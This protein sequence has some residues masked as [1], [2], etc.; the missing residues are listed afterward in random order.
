MKFITNKGA[1]DIPLE[2]LE[3]QENGRLVFF[4]GAGISYPAGL[5]VFSQLVNDVFD[6]LNEEPNGLEAQ[7]IK[8]KAFDR[9]LGLLEARLQGDR[10]DPHNF[11]RREI[12]KKLTL[13]EGAN[14]KTHKAL[15]NLSISSSNTH[16]IVT[17]NVDLGFQQADKSV[18]ACT[19]NAPK[20]PVPKEHKW[21][22][23]VHL[24]GIIDQTLD[25]DGEHL[26]FTSGDFGSAYLTERWASKFVTELFL[27]F[28]VVFVGYSID[29]PVMRYIT[30][31]IAA[32][33]RRG[34]QL[35]KKAYVLAE[36]LPS[37]MESS[38]KIWLSKGAEP[39][40]Y[41]KGGKNHPN[42][43]NSLIAWAKHVSSGLNSKKAYLQREGRISPVSKDDNSEAVI[44]VLD[45]IRERSNPNNKEITGALALSFVQIEPVAPFGW[46]SVFN[47]YNLLDQVGNDNLLCLAYSPPQYS[48]AF[49]IVSPSKVTSTLWLWL[50]KHLNTREFVEWVITKGSCLHPEFKRMLKWELET[51]NKVLLSPKAKVFW[52]IQL[53]GLVESGDSGYLDDKVLSPPINNFIIFN[54]FTECIQPYISFEKSYSGGFYGDKEENLEVDYRSEVKIRLKEYDFNRLEKLKSYP[55]EYITYLDSVN[56]ALQKAM[57]IWQLTSLSEDIYDKSHW[58]LSSIAKHPQNNRFN[59]WTLLIELIR[60]LWEATFDK[61]K[62]DAIQYVYKWNSQPFPIFKRLIFH[63]LTVRNVLTPDQSLDLLLQDNGKWLWDSSTKLERTRFLQ[64]IWTQISDDSTEKLLGMILETKGTDYECWLLLKKLKLCEPKLNQAAEEFL[65]DI[66]IKNS[67]WRFSGDESEDFSSWSTTTSGNDS[68]I[69]VS[70]LKTLLTDSFDLAIEKLTEK[71]IRYTDGRNDCLRYLSK[72]EPSLAIEFL[73]YVSMNDWYESIWHSCLVGLS[74]AENIEWKGVAQLILKLSDEHIIEEQWAIAFW[75]KS[76]IHLSKENKECLHLY[77]LLLNKVLCS[78]SEVEIEVSEDPINAAINNSVGIITE[79]LVKTIS[80][81]NLKTD[82]CIPEGE[83]REIATLLLRKSSGFKYGKII[84]ASRLHYLHAVDPDW[85]EK[86]LLPFFNYEHSSDAIYMWQSYLWNPRISA[87]LARLLKDSLL[88]SIEQYD[89]FGDAKRNLMQIF[90]L[91]SIE[92]EKLFT[93][94]MIGKVLREVGENGLI[95]VSNFL[96]NQVIQMNDEA[97]I[98][99]K[100]KVKPILNCWP[101]SY[102]C[103]SK[104]VSEDFVELVMCLDNEFQEAVKLIEPFLVKVEYSYSVIKAIEGS[105]L[106]TKYPNDVFIILYKVIDLGGQYVHDANKLVIILDQLKESE[107]R[108][109]EQPTFIKLNDFANEKVNY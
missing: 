29:D 3:A 69:N 84:L 70:Q 90:I 75:I 100:N 30:D 56:E 108:L 35:F 80:N 44:R 68:D 12:I 65:S 79:S 53:S 43:H 88:I 97:D 83:L 40:L 106:L 37:E 42:L 59:S 17:T 74:D 109:S 78:L 26:V 9:A 21:K 34:D 54:K 72:E 1:P 81:F 85:T 87:D 99:W 15:L 28:T 55:V 50:I 63:A 77:Y 94:K 14:L 76:S 18:V 33:K 13:Q 11:V 61:N 71:E 60:D 57:K 10:D 7:A 103:R 16:R 98:Y 64:K 20:L 66:T 45:I 105:A 48:Y 82:E 46:F 95:N 62:D 19:D 51:N 27:N 67:E 52:E 93:R 47:K 36:S 4:C 73:T 102:E 38:K 31:A 96:S 104:N 8:S 5:P 22:S 107:P 92:F 49:N 2:V 32:E 86:N 6:G 101:K 58:D 91:A 41:S 24:H 89:A 39:I 23:V 25:P